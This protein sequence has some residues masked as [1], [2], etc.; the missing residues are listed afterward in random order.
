MRRSVMISLAAGTAAALLL[1]PPSAG[2]QSNTPTGYEDVLNGFSWRNIGPN[3]GGRSLAISGSPGRPFEYY[4]GAT[5]GGVWKTTD[6]GTTWHPVTDGQ[7]TSSS[8]GALAI[9]ET[10][11][12]IVYIGGGET[13]LRGSITQGDGVYKTVDGGETWRH[14]GLRETQAISRIRIHPTNP[15]IVYVAALGHPYGPNAERGVFRST[16]GGVNWKK[17]L[18][19]S[20]SAGAVDLIIDRTN[21]NVIYASIWQVYRKAWK[22][23]GGGPY[24]GL[25]KSTDGGDTWTELT[26]NPGMPEP[27]IGKIG[28]AVSP[29]D[30]N[31]VYAMVE[32]NEGGVFRSDDGAA[33]SPPTT[34]PNRQSRNNHKTKTAWKRC[35]PYRLPA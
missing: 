33:A 7:I 24:S 30:P 22:M 14:M 28:V 6:G 10:N 11:P 1:A 26:Q 16:D 12:D 31:R 20:D 34:H 35:L 4:F 15:D 18:F 25:H 23:W 27:P 29:A 21:P 8:I 2:A 5:G 3:R 17:I 19:V 13:E 9:A 32:A